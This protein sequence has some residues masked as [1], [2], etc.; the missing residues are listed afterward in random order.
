MKLHYSPKKNPRE[1]VIQKIYSKTFNKEE[2]ITFEKHRFK[3]F[4]KDVVL[5][6]LERDEVLYEE[7]N[8]SLNDIKFQN[9]DKIL[10]T[11]IKSAA[12][13]LLYKTKIPKKIIIKEYL[14]VSNFFIDSSKTKYLNALLDK[15]SKEVR[16]NNE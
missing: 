9:M 6:T 16:K 3:K 1:I 11:I 10:Q 13:E 7:I 15:I 2:K 12:Y 5:G 14:N 4:I 8:K